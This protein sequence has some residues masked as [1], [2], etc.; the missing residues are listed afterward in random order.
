VDKG[1]G[2]LKPAYIRAMVRALQENNLLPDGV[3]GE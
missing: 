2:P 1:S 3:R